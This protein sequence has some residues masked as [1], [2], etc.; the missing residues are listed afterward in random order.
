[1]SCS[2][3]RRIHFP[4]VLL[5]L[6]STDK[7]NF[8]RLRFAVLEDLV[9]QLHLGSTPAW[10]KTR[11]PAQ[12]AYA[13]H[14]IVD[15]AL[16]IVQQRLCAAG[17]ISTGSHGERGRSNGVSDAQPRRHAT[18]IELNEQAWVRGDPEHT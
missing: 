6:H 12:T 11:V 1:M 4:S 13:R 15:G 9:S 16:K 3:R 14:A 8:S 17:G 5:V 10:H 7:D 18:P 2:I